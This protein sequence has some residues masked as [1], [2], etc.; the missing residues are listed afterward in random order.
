[1]KQEIVVDGL[2]DS[3]CGRKADLSLIQDDW[4]RQLEVRNTETFEVEGATFTFGTQLE[5]GDCNGSFAGNQD[6]HFQTKMTINVSHVPR[7]FALRPKTREKVEKTINDEANLMFEALKRQAIITKFEL[8]HS[9][10]KFQ[11]AGCTAKGSHVEKDE[12]FFDTIIPSCRYCDR[13]LYLDKVQHACLRCPRGTYA[14]VENDDCLPCPLV[15]SAKSVSGDSLS[16]CYSVSVCSSCVYNQM[17]EG[18]LIVVSFHLC[19][20]LLILW[21]FRSAAFGKFSRTSEEE[22]KASSVRKS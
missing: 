22:D 17:L 2:R 4:K 12:Q 19:I 11:V 21:S 7:T 16:D 5:G 15:E 14:R 13:G 3:K 18:F 1:M 8:T 6:F 20:F 10:L 9:S